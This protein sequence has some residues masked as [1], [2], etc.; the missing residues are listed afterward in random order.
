MTIIKRRK[1]VNYLQVHNFPVQ[2]DLEDL[3]AIGLLTYVMSLPEDWTIHKT[4]L[5]SQFSRR[6]TDGAWKLLAEKGYAI[7]FSC[8]IKGRVKFFYTVSDVAFTQKEYL[9][10]V[11]EELKGLLDDPKIWDKKSLIPISNLK[12][13]QDNIFDIPMMELSPTDVQNVQQCTDVQNVQQTI[14]QNVQHKMYSTICTVQNVHLINKHIK[15][16]YSQK[17]RNKENKFVNKEDAPVNNFSNINNET[18]QT[19]NNL[20]K[21]YMLKGLHKDLCLRVTKEALEKIDYIDN[22]GGYLRVCLEGT[23]KKVHD[24]QG[25]YDLTEQLEELQQPNGI[26]M[27]D[28]IRNGVQH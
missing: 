27:M 28:W 3:A 22:F 18:E 14:A 8:Y 10:F 21:E 24:K 16:I 20:C 25:Q 2:K 17:N 13:M 11:E 26:I 6:K 23:L 5:Q 1:T 7:G 15:K 12:P 9:E 4:Q 19:I